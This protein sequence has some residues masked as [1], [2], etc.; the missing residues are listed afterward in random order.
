MS[1][2]HKLF[3]LTFVSLLFGGFLLFS[4]SEDILEL[5]E[6]Q[7]SPVSEASQ[8]VPGP[9]VVRGTITSIEEPAS[10]PWEPTQVA[11]YSLERSEENQRG[12]HGYTW[13]VVSSESEFSPFQ[14]TSGG[15]SLRVVPASEH[16]FAVFR[17]ETHREGKERDRLVWL[18]EGDTVEIIGTVTIAE[19]GMELHFPEEGTFRRQ[20][21]TD[22][23]IEEGVD[24]GERLLFPWSGFAL[25][26]VGLA[27]GFSLMSWRSRPWAAPGIAIFGG[28]LLLALSI[29]LSIAD[30]Q[31]STAAEAEVTEA[32]TD[33]IQAGAISEELGEETLRMRL[34]QLELQR[35]GIPDRWL[36][37]GVGAGEPVNV[38][39]GTVLRQLRP[40]FTIILIQL[41]LTVV[42]FVGSIVVVNSRDE[43]NP[44]LLVWTT[45]AFALSTYAVLLLTGIWR[46]GGIE[47]LFVAGIW[48]FLVAG[49]SVLYERYHQR[50]LAYI[51]DV[52]FPDRENVH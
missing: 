9:A 33:A 43:S 21:I 34:E 35:R 50:S 36:R 42:L 12:E 5:R 28:L 48:C 25:I 26:L 16:N 3:F 41:F 4:S 29:A 14:I 17:S 44:W 46:S 19:S 30:L 32:I 40:D 39:E 13:R 7:R 45:V 18:T 22:R 51:D 1:V 2:D 6:L 37:E 10:H 15:S 11:Y 8:A 27:A 38:G 20:L 23:T 31:R 52:G 47:Q 24:A 49:G